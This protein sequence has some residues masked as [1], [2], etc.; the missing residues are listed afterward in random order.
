MRVLWICNI[1][2]PAVARDLGIPGS[3]KEGWLV[4]L[5]EMILA[6]RAENNIELHVA[7]PADHALDGRTGEAEGIPYHAFYEDIDHAECN[8]P[9]LPRRIRAVCDEVRPDVIHCFGTEY[10]HTLAAL[11]CGYDK[12]RILVGIQGVCMEIARRYMADLPVEVQRSVTFRDWLK[13]DTIR[14]QRDKYVRRGLREQEILKRAVHITGRTDFDKTYALHWNPQANYYPANETLRPCFYQGCWERDKAQPHTIFISQADYP[15]KGLHY[16]LIASARLRERFPDLRIRVAGNSIVEYTTWKQKLKISAYGR[17][18]RSLIDRYGMTDRIRFL[19]KLDAEKMKREYLHCGLF[20]CCSAN[21]NSPNSLGEAMLLG[22]PCVAADVGGI[23][24]IFT[25]GEDGILYHAYSADV[26]NDGY[27]R[28]E[29]LSK[30]A[31]DLYHAVCRIWT[32]EKITDE[33]CNH[34]RIHAGKNHDKQQNYT[35]MTEIY[36]RIESENTPC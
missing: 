26:N 13:R 3:P 6:H 32:D 21:E 33:F 8:D 22:V 36:K 34:A 20:L 28:R 1:A 24:S 35:K 7:F 14:Q 19:G 25:D 30:T 18:L 10:Q 16:L 17:Y 5:S 31:Q 9:Q 27:Y 23:P 15:L 12:A 2:L 4:G 11:Q 29:N